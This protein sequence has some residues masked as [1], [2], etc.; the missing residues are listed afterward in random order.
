[1]YL[2][3]YPAAPFNNLDMDIDGMFWIRGYLGGY[4]FEEEFSASIHELIM[5]VS[6]LEGH[7]PLIGPV[8]FWLH[9]T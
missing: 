6:K 8:L 1:M 2:A 5:A 9:N 3:F 7:V 4:Q